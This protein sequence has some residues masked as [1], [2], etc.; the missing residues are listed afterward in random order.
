MTYNGN[1]IFPVSGKMK[2]GDIKMLSSYYGEDNEDLED[3]EFDYAIYNDETINKF[4]QLAAM[5]GLDGY[6][7]KR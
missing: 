7:G 4:K 2:H 1:G 6:P 3:E 5:A